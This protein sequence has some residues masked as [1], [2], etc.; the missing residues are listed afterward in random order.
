LTFFNWL[1]H[2]S[3]CCRDPNITAEYSGWQTSFL[4]N[5]VYQADRPPQYGHKD[6]NPFFKDMQATATWIFPCANSN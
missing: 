1:R 5:H 3:S 6:W 4:K 2:D